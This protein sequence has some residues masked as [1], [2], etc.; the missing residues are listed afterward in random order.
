MEG[1][2]FSAVD[3]WEAYALLLPYEFHDLIDRLLGSRLWKE[4][5]MVGRFLTLSYQVIYGYCE[6]PQLSTI[7]KPW[8]RLD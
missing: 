6:A 2:W 7:S 1:S 8:T 5:P 4:H 3:P